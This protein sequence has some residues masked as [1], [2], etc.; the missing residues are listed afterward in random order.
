MITGGEDKR[1]VVNKIESGVLTQTGEFE[2]EEAVT[3]V[4]C[5]NNNM[6]FAIV[7]V[8]SGLLKIWNV[9]EKECV[10]KIEGFGRENNILDYLIL[11][12]L[13]D[14]PNIYVLAMG[15]GEQFMKI[16]DVDSTKFQIV[17]TV[18]HNNQACRVGLDFEKTGQSVQ[19]VSGDQHGEV[20]FLQVNKDKLTGKAWINSCLLR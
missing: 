12:C 4:S 20:R 17:K 5:F 13:T 15:R 9:T 11:T 19:L 8:K 6:S 2:E 14:Q 18:M 10:S 7:V 16:S 1:V 3:R